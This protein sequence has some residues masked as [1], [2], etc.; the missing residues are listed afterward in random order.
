MWT[1]VFS[2]CSCDEP[3]AVDWNQVQNGRKRKKLFKLETFDIT[4]ST[5]ISEN[6]QLIIPTKI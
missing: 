2:V 5:Y 6:S 3:A 4:M 1:S